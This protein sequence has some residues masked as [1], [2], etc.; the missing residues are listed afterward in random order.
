VLEA[1]RI[2]NKH[3]NLGDA[4]YA[5]RERAAGDSSYKGDSWRHPNVTAYS[6][7]VKVLHEEGV[8]TR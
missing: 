5:V 6:D 2:I 7:V 8:L 4:V 3:H 1:I